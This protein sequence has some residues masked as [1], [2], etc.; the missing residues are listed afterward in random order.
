V[1]T[2]AQLDMLA[3]DGCDE[4]QGYFFSRPLPAD[5]ATD[6]LTQQAQRAE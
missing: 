6:F 5:V 1:E 4:V 2:A 3:T